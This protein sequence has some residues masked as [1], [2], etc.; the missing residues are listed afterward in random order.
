MA[1]A[2]LIAGAVTL[3]AQFA[4]SHHQWWVYLTE[5]TW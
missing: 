2:H 4:R 1:M 5:V 3:V